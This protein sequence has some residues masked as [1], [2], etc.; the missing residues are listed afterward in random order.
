MN[1][2]V[3][4]LVALCRWAVAALFLL[5][6]LIKV[7]DPKGFLYKIEEYIEVFHAAAPGLALRE[8]LLPLAP[9]AALSIAA[10]EV[11]VAI[12]LIL[13]LWR[14]L[15]TGLLLAMII[16]FTLLTGYSAMTGAVSDCGCFGEVLQ[17]TP[18]QSFYKDLVL[19]GLIALL[20]VYRDRIRPL[21]ESRLWRT[22]TA[23]VLVALT[24][25]AVQHSYRGLPFVDFSAFAVGKNIPAG[26]A[27]R[28]ASGERVIKDYAPLGRACGYD[29]F[30]GRVLWVVAREAEALAPA[31]VQ[32]IAALAADT[33]R[34]VALLTASGSAA[35]AAVAQQLAQLPGGS[36]VCLVGQDLTLVKTIVR[37]SPGY[38][39]LDS[40]TV[41]GKWPAHQPPTPQDLVP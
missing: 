36:R 35:R 24:V 19:L 41:I 18:E 6:G 38:L 27:A 25:L 14:A 39:L 26:L 12:L 3:R 34:R 10:V 8:W 22:L 29:E 21:P 13:G 20:V 5:S 15:T 2:F 30:Q 23:A 17:L 9:L 7:N 11:A 4:A 37:S 1:P 33:T 28:K 16:F 32:H 31:Q 40:G